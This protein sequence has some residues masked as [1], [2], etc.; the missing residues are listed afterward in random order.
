MTTFLFDLFF[1]HPIGLHAILFDDAKSALKSA[2]KLQFWD[3]A[4][5]FLFNRLF[6]KMK[7]ECYFFFS[8]DATH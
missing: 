4:L 7:Y 3:V 5:F 8:S 2:K 6:E 1:F